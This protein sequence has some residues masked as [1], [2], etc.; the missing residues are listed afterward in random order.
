[1]SKVVADEKRQYSLREETQDLSLIAIASF[2]VIPYMTVIASPVPILNFL[3]NLLLR[4]LRGIP[5]FLLPELITDT[6][7]ELTVTVE[8]LSPH[9]KA[10]RIEQEPTIG[11][12]LG[13]TVKVLGIFPF[14]YIT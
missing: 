4:N 13:K 10:V 2:P 5:S 9:H 11:D 8:I 7:Q 12:E 6:E 14:N 1:M 3:I